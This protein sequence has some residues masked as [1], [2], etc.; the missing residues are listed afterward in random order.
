MEI[1]NDGR[2]GIDWEKLVEY[3]SANFDLDRFL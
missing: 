3:N 2:N 1:F